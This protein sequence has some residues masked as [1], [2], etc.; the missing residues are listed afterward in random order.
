MYI[1][2]GAV[3][4]DDAAPRA[5]DA[6]RGDHPQGE[7]DPASVLDRCEAGRLAQRLRGRAS[8]HRQVRR[9]ARGLRSHA[10]GLPHRR[11][12]PHAQCQ[13]GPGHER[14]DAGR[15]Q[16][17][18]EARLGAHRSQPG[19]A[20]VDLLRRAA[21]GRAAAHRL[22][23]GMVDAH[24]PQARRDHRPAGTGHLLPRDRRVPVRIHDALRRIDDRDGCRAPA[25]RGGLPARQAIQLGR[26]RARV[27]RQRRAPRP[28]RQGRRAL[29]HLRLRRCARRRR[30]VG[31][32]PR[33]PSGCRR[34]IRPWRDSP[35]SAP[36]STPSSTSR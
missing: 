4:E 27:R 6:D 10:A 33:G 23:P 13:G 26:S 35:Q 36:T 28:P 2:L 29:A 1:D 21:A 19:I 30:A 8:D 14:V 3:A 15:L 22:R 18:L 20:A 34:R 31:A 12:V 17:R 16:P 5:P 9:C 32:R 25:A 24:G 11:R 7:R